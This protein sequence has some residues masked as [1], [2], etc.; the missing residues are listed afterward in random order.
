MRKGLVIV[1]VVLLVIG[2]L[3]AMVGMLPSLS[4]VK[5]EDIEYDDVSGFTDYDDG[6]DV[7]ITGEITEEEQEGGN[8]IYA[9]DD[10]VIVYAEEDIGDEGDTITVQCRVEEIIILEATTERMKAYRFYPAVN[11]LMIIGIILVIIGIIV[12]ILGIKGGEAAVVQEQPPIEQPPQ[13]PSMP[14]Q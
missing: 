1:G 8:Y 7:I 3:L 5:A 13:Q 10:N 9:L 6:D 14:P 12:I 4:A 11:I 2:L